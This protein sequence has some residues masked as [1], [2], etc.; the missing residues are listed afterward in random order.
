VLNSLKISLILLLTYTTLQAYDAPIGQKEFVNDAK[1]VLFTPLQKRVAYNAKIVNFKPLSASD[2][3]FSE[4]FD[5]GSS[6]FSSGEAVAYL[7]EVELSLKP[8]YGQRLE[9]FFEK[10]AKNIYKGEVA[11]K[12]SITIYYT[13]G[14]DNSRVYKSFELHDKHYS[15]LKKV[16]NSLHKDRLN[17]YINFFIGNKTVEKKII[18]RKHDFASI[19]YNLRANKIDSSTKLDDISNNLADIVLPYKK[20]GMYKFD[21]IANNKRLYYVVA[22]SKAQSQKLRTLKLDLKW[23]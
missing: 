4:F 5:F 3:P 1:R 14:E 7:A 11:K 2:K 8:T 18:N 20:F 6:A 12:N 16:A 9:S 17:I 22:L 10:Y 21:F 23:E 15:A 19:Y 13:N